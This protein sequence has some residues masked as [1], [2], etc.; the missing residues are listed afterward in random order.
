MQAFL[1]QNVYIYIYILK[2]YCK[3]IVFTQKT[4]SVYKHAL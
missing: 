3:L 4:L 1:L 2:V